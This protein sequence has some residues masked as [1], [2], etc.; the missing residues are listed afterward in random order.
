MHKNEFESS[1]SSPSS[2]FSLRDEG[3]ILL[4]TPRTE[5]A[6]EWIDTHVGPDNGFQPLYPTLVIEPRFAGAIL[7]GVRQSGLGSVAV[8]P[9]PVPSACS[10]CNIPLAEFR[11]GVLC[12][13][14]ASMSAAVCRPFF[15]AAQAE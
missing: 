11:D 6:R 5:S 10:N 1:G 4:L 2:D 13:V 8:N 7:E 15:H 3:S 12:D 9:N 14:C